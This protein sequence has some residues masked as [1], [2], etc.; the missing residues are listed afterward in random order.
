MSASSSTT[1]A[2]GAPSPGP[3]PT[4]GST[5]SKAGASGTPSSAPAASPGS[6]AGSTAGAKKKPTKKKAAAPGEPKT[7][8]PPK[9]RKPATKPSGSSTSNAAMVQAAKEANADL[10][11]QRAQAAAR[12]TDPLWY[13]IEDVLPPAL[14][15]EEA[16]QQ[17]EHI[18]MTGSSSSILPEQVHIVE[19][20]LKF[21][22]MTRSDVTPQAMA[23][24]LE[25]ARRYASELQEDAQDYAAHAAGLFS[26]QASV[27]KAPGASATGGPWP[28]PSSKDYMLAAEMRP[29]HPKAVTAQLPKLMILAQQI[30]SVPLP[31]IPPHVYN[32]ILL[33]P[34]PH[35][36]TARTFDVVTGAH[37]A[38]K[39]IQ[40]PPGPSKSF[41]SSILAAA[42]L[43]K[44]AA[45][46]TKKNSKTGYGVTRSPQ[47]I[48]IKL[49][50]AE[51]AVPSETQKASLGP[52]SMDTSS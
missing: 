9:K 41:A 29:D 24:L 23:C 3:P 1:P 11:L 42:Q 25:Q 46:Q 32:G 12:R 38:Q 28:D 6:K 33:P 48:P 52:T 40:A 8:K 7:K 26:T 20:A 35:A 51:T 30:N 36:L 31:P 17:H 45:A 49:K 39:M 18:A 15:K 43:D 19:N 10:A 14:T 44:A 5:T 22:N 2:A 34:E 16:K 37:V 4:A 47:V 50:A 27:G 21:N 13:R